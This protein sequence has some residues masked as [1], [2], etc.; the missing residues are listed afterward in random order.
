[1][2]F[3]D[4]KSAGDLIKSQDWDDFVDFAELISSNSYGHSSNTSI[5]L[6]SI[7]KTD[8]TDSGDTS[9]HIHDSRYYTETE[10][11]AGQLDSRYYTESEVDAISGAIISHVEAN[12]QPSGVTSSFLD[13]FYASSLGSALSGSYSTHRQD[14]TIHFTKSSIDDDYAG[15]SQIRTYI[16]TIS[17]ALDTKIDTK[18]DSTAASGAFYPSSLGKGVSGAVNTLTLWYDASASKLSNLANSGNEYSDAYNWFVESSSKLSESSFNSDNYIISAN[19]I[20]RFADSSS[21]Y[22]QTWI[23]TFSGNIDNRIDSLEADTFDHEQYITSA[24]AIDR[25]HPSA[26][27]NFP[28]ISTQTI[29]GV[30]S[31]DVIADNAGGSHYK[32]SKLLDLNY[33]ACVLSGC[34]LTSGSNLGTGDVSKGVA[35][36]RIENQNAGDVKI[37]DVEPSSNMALS[38]GLNYIYIDYNNGSPVT[39]FKTT[40][41]FNRNTQFPIGQIWKSRTDDIQVINGG[42]RF[43]NIAQKVQRRFGETDGQIR[44]E[45]LVTSESSIEDLALNVTAGIFWKGINRFATSE[46]DTGHSHDITCVNT[47]LN[48]FCAT[49][50]VDAHLNRGRHIYVDDST[51]NDGIYK[52]SSVTV[53]SS[54]YWRVYTYKDIPDTT[55]DGHIHDECYYS[56]YRTGANAGS[57][58]NQWYK[59]S[60]QIHLDVNHYD[61][62]TGTLGE[63]GNS[64]FGTHWLYVDPTGLPCIVYG[65]DSRSLAD[66][67]LASIPTPLPES[68]TSIYSLV[69]KIIVEQGSTD[70]TSAE[71]YTPWSTTFTAGSVTRHNDLSNIQGGIAGQYYHLTATD[72]TN[73]NTLT[74][75][76]DASTLHHHDGRYYTETESNT[77]FPASSLVNKT[78]LDN[79]SSNAKAAFEFSSNSDLVKSGY[80]EVANGGTI[81][82]GL[83]DIP[84]YV[85]ASPSG[86]SVNFGTTCA[87]DETNITVYMTAGGTRKVFWTASI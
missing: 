15:S 21:V 8:L 61:D 85:N 59:L 45:G 22:N 26:L 62:G 86:Y 64:K 68:I 2:A 73:F 14:S 83:P 50:G 20:E 82:H 37:F 29:S 70:L 66:A 44:S 36:A 19:A 6:T 80:A 11:N 1:M 17:G 71:I 28:Y 56:Y 16:N 72:D 52:V 18:L 46:I 40:S 7:Q 57:D 24:N 76:G 30:T 53:P 77:K 42:Y 55:V 12:F 5:H 33:A 35:I 47:T 41:G 78:Y 54:G 23:D 9:L 39:K 49:G 13:D 51:G 4:N 75:T 32:L 84:K 63:I 31:F 3:N 65:R 60:G 43:D 34:I 25:F 79:V 38:Y 27:G 87:V 81:A 69:A 48:Y 58:P 74:G 10:L 67:Q